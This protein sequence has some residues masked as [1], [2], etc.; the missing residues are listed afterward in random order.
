MASYRFNQKEVHFQS[1]E[2]PLD[3]KLLE[4]LLYDMMDDL[5]QNT[6]KTHPITDADKKLLLDRI[7]KKIIE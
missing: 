5:W 1:S 2:H 6:I 3:K 7:R 4:K